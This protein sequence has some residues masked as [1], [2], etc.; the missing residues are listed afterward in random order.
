MN[1]STAP[2][3]LPHISAS[4][5]A[6]HFSLFVQA[7]QQL[8]GHVSF[9]TV[10]CIELLVD[11]YRCAPDILCAV[12]FCFVDLSTPFIQAYHKQIQD[13]WDDAKWRHICFPVAQV[14][15]HMN[16]SRSNP[17]PHKVSLSAFPI[18]KQNTLV[19][20]T[21]A[22]WWE[23]AMCILTAGLVTGELHLLWWSK[24]REHG[25]QVLRGGASWSWAS[26][27]TLCVLWVFLHICKH[28]LWE[29]NYWSN[30]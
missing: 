7:Q 15:A 12:S 25:Y 8:A 2:T 26:S 16:N 13:F 30:A 23:L 22:S 24:S 6:S 5:W 27:A 11:R 28:Q 9:Q 14:P 17:Q 21:Y 4:A 19:N 29:S 20:K 3:T 18:C 10:C 1:I